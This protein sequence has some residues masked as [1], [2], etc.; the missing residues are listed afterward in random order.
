MDD[1]G[2][3]RSYVDLPKLNLKFLLNT[4]CFELEHLKSDM[5]YAAA[6]QTSLVPPSIKAVHPR[7]PKLQL[8]WQLI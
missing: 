7:C 2:G 6:T 5:S 8:T 3:M 4:T 1:R